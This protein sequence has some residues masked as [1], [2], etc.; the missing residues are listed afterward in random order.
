MS[1]LMWAP[2]AG[3]ANSGDTP[4]VVNYFTVDRSELQHLQR[5]VTAGHE[6]WCKDPRL[7]AAEE[8]KRLAPDFSGDA[9]ELQVSNSANDAANDGAAKMTFVWAP[10]DSRA[11]YRVTVQ[12]F[13]W[14]LPIAKNTDALIWV[15][16]I[17]QVELPS[18]ATHQPK[19]E[20]ARPASSRE[21]LNNA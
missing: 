18:R 1:A 20:S 9:M 16:T 2:V 13:D 8:F 10:L 7:V 14:L 11:I 21:R 15:P 12:R 4:A 17:V 19:S 6:D 5:W 3:A